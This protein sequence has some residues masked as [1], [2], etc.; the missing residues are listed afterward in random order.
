M[1][2]KPHVFLCHSHADKPFVRRIAKELDELNVD[3]WLDEWE[4]STGDSLH[5]CIGSA[6]DASAYVAVTLSRHSIR[7]KWCRSELRAALAREMTLN[8]NLVLPILRQR[9]RVPAFLADRL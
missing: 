5:D 9:V 3:V 2:A 8:R 1:S 4:L 7:S 6:L